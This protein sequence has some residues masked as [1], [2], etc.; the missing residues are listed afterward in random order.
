M[1]DEISCSLY[2]WKWQRKPVRGQEKK[3]AVTMAHKFIPL[4]I[5]L[6]KVTGKASPGILKNS[7][8]SAKFST[9]SVL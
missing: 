4:K 7:E 8:A 9:R 6:K 1:N 3:L 5:G 2:A